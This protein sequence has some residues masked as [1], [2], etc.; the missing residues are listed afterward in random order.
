MSR[1]ST[2]IEQNI[3]EA[4]MIE[5]FPTVEKRVDKFIASAMDAMI[6]MD[7]DFR[8]VL[9]N[10]AAERMFRCRAE[11]VLGTPIDRFI[12]EQLRAA[13]RKHV[14]KFAHSPV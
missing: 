13:H 4:R 3:A 11:D 8:I 7:Q 10:P 5:R 9:F 2:G 1:P 6:T 14:R 12:P